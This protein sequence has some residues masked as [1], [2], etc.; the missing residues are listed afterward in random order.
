VGAT[1]LTHL[2][3]FDGIQLAWSPPCHIRPDK[4]TGTSSDQTTETWVSG[5][6]NDRST[7]RPKATTSALLAET[8]L[9]IG[10]D[11]PVN[12]SVDVSTEVSTVR[13]S[14]AVY[15]P[16]KMDRPKNQHFGQIS[17]LQNYP[18]VPKVRE[19]AFSRMFLHL[20][21]DFPHK[22]LVVW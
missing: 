1:E 21:T 13:K 20:L 15:A 8:F 14:C 3:A 2:L 7:G 5:C 12:R 19:P 9:G 6:L 4:S 22:P 10:S 17:P 11:S 18:L 16:H